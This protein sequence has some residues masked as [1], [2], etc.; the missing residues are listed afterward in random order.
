MGNNKR[1]D[2]RGTSEKEKVCISCGRSKRLEHFSI[3]KHSGTST[4]TITLPRCKGCMKLE[5]YK[6]HLKNQYDLSWETYLRMV[7]EQEGKCFLCGS[8]PSGKDS[9]LHVDHNHTTGEIRK[10]LCRPCNVGI[11]MFKEDP[12]LLLKVIQYIS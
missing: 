6:R 8:F 7:E 4:G 12:A 10:L 2:T 11:G 5:K 1:L 9:K 3:H